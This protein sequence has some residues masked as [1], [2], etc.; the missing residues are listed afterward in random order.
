[1]DAFEKHLADYIDTCRSIFNKYR[2]RSTKVVWL[3]TSSPQEVYDESTFRNAVDTAEDTPEFEAVVEI[4]N[5]ELLLDD[6]DRLEKVERKRRKREQERMQKKGK[7]Q[8]FPEIDRW[9]IGT[10]RLATKRFFRNTGSYLKLWCGLEVELSSLVEIAVN[11]TTGSKPEFIQMLVFDGFALFDDKRPL[12]HV[13][14][15][16]GE[17]R[18]Y[19]EKELESM[20]M[21]PQ[22]RWHDR[23]D[24]DAPKRIALWYVLTVRESEPYRGRVGIWF[25]DM[26]VSPFGF[27]TIGKTKEANVELIGPIYLCLGDSANLAEEIELRTNVFDAVPVLS[28]RRN[29]YLPWDSYDEAGN[30]QP[31][32]SIKRIGKDGIILR[33]VFDMWIMV[34]KLAQEGFLRFPTETYVRAVMNWQ[35]QASRS[36]QV[37]VDLVTAIESVL[38]PGSRLELGYKTAIRGASLLAHSAKERSKALDLLDRFYK[39][40]S[41]IVHEGHSGGR[42]TQRFIDYALLEMARHILLRYIFALHLGLQGD[43]SDWGL[44]DGRLL[45][46]T[47]KRPATIN[48][49]L[50]A[51]VIDPNLTSLLEAKLQEQGL[52][53]KQHWKSDLISL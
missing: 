53:E 7:T 10:A 35:A 19:S 18:L 16:V 17:F 5:R 24:L 47:D 42:D 25:K 45:S 6:L 52:F 37:F 36:D 48:R 29:E 51:F 41:V 4:V 21:L 39:T 49:I 50:D 46:S 31:R 12:N 43:L 32:S 33:R 2:D 8:D 28:R 22:T 34:N 13:Q 40:R 9:R 14:L 27:D 30:E 44:S 1:M 26:M 20:F 23:F 15:P 11:K 38:T 3:P